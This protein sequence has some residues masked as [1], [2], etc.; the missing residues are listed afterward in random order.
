MKDQN[1][2]P[3]AMN[4]AWHRYHTQFFGTEIPASMRQKI[5]K[6][7][8]DMIGMML[9]D[10]D[11]MFQDLP[12]DCRDRA[13]LAGLGKM[14]DMEIDYTGAY[15]TELNVKKEV[16][17][18]M[19]A[20]VRRFQEQQRLEEV[21][22]QERTER[23]AQPVIVENPKAKRLHD[24]FD[25]CYDWAVRQ[26][27]P[28]YEAN[29]DAFLSLLRECNRLEGIEH[30]VIFSLPL[31]K[32]IR[33]DQRVIEALNNHPSLRDDHNTAKLTINGRVW[34]GVEAK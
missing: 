29:V 15:A 21:I 22:Q 24:I 11:E 9:T 20:V 25:A 32:E 28:R 17:R 5:A 12:Q 14:R 19:S 6:P 27:L 26:G 34:K 2:R 4:P 8:V 23:E 10:L 31:K 16:F 30:Y 13:V 33:N 1:G 18:T 3:D 7:F